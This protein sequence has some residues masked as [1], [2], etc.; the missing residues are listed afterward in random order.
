MLAGSLGRFSPVTD[1][2][3]A[4]TGEQPSHPK[5]AAGLLMGG[6]VLLILLLAVASL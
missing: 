5:L 1:P 4:P 6:V 3:R 2:Q